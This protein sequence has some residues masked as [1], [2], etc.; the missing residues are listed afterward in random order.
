MTNRLFFSI[1]ILLSL[2]G[3][4]ASVYFIAVNVQASQN[5]ELYGVTG[6]DALFIFLMQ[7]SSGLFP[8]FFLIFTGL[9]LIAASSLLKEMTEKNKLTAELISKLPEVSSQSQEITQNKASE[10]E[11]KQDVT[12]EK[13]ISPP[14]KVQ[15]DE[16]RYYWKG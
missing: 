16:E 9:L 4:A 15:N 13:I 2:L 7:T 11:D 1:G 14:V 10:I 8:Y 6:N 5:Q 3:T 12:P